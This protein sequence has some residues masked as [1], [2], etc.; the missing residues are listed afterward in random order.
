[1]ADRPLQYSI[2][3]DSTLYR[4]YERPLPKSPEHAKR[5]P[6]AHLWDEIGCS[7]T[8]EG[9]RRIRN[10]H[11]AAQLVQPPRRR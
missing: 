6:G 10:N 2:R 5:W 9:A 1:M 8:E 11:Q 4:V 3:H 7:Q